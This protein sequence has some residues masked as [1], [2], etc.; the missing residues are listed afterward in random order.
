MSRVTVIG[1]G[2][3]G[4]AVGAALVQSGHDVTFCARTGFSELSVRKEGEPPLIFPAHV[5]TQPGA[6][7]PA[8]WVLVCVKTYQVP[9]VADWLT[10][11]VG[12]DTKVAVIQ[13]GVEQLENAQPFVP[14]A[15]PIVPVVIDLPVSRTAPGV[16][17]WKRIAVASVPESPAG[18]EF[19]ELFGG[20]FLAVSATPDFVTRAWLKLCNNAP[21]GAI[22]ALSGERMSVMKEPGIADLARAIL[23]ECI[24]VGRAEGA[25][26]DDEVMDRQ[27]AAFLSAGGDEGNSMYEDRMA[28]RPMEWEARN[29][30]IPRKGARH[31]IATPVSAAL[32]PLLR[33]ISQRGG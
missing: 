17:V 8:D 14:A 23:A 30:V 28:G 20:S 2:A 33:A 18:R 11:T 27:I 22:L 1:P 25:C 26:L 15:T 31:G 24:A 4:C 21:S 10:A 12:P 32:V 7:M 13:N 5:V 16:A 9:A 19:A 29:G 6:A 3:I